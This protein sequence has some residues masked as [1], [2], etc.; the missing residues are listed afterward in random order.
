MLENK[1][2]DKIQIKDKIYIVEKSI[3]CDDCDLRAAKKNGFLCSDIEIKNIIGR[4]DAEGRK[5]KISII[6]KE[7]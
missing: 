1:I 7:L 5:D 2:G 3:F 6:F 4:C